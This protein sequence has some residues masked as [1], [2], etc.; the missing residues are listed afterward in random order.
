MNADIDYNDI[1]QQTFCMKAITI[2][3]VPEDLARALKNETRQR[4]T[5]LNQTVLALLTQA[6]GLGSQPRSNGLGDLAGTWSQEELEAFESATALF[7]QVDEE[8]W[9]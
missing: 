5:S 7:K 9:S 1:I 3:N 2:R 4:G 8:R 6:V